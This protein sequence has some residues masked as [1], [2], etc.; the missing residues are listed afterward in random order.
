MAGLARR[1]A[2]RLPA[3]P[4]SRSRRLAG[5]AVLHQAAAHFFHGDDGGLLGGGGQHRTRAALQLPGALGRHDD[6][7]VGALLRIVR[8]GAVR[9][10]AGGFVSHIVDT[11][12]NLKCFQNGPDL[13]FDPGPPHPLGAHD[14]AQNGVGLRQ[15]AIDQ[16][17]IVIVVLPD[18]LGRFPQPPLDHL[19]PVLA[20]RAQPAAPESAAR[21][22]G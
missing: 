4:A 21:E 19:V 3:R 20:A 2:Y 8:D 6:E 16:D 1:P 10:V 7:P 18:L 12:S 5:Q 9:V 22:P 11:S 17:I 14:R 15:V 13:I